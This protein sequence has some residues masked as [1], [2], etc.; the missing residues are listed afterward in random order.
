MLTLST[1]VHTHKAS[2]TCCTHSVQRK[3]IGKFSCVCGKSWCSLVLRSVWT[4][5]QGSSGGQCWAL[6][7]ASVGP[8][9]AGLLDQCEGWGAEQTDA[10]RRRRAHSAAAADPLH[11]E[12]RSRRCLFH[13]ICSHPS[14]LSSVNSV[15]SCLSSLLVL[16]SLAS[17][18]LSCLIS[19]L[20]LSPH[21]DSSHLV[22]SPHLNSCV[23]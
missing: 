3:T 15:S 1:T 21:L 8:G 18:F 9:G 10:H 11:G 22:S 12:S 2:F 4:C 17:S 7:P 16:V 5:V 23:V 6:E 14:R 19:S 13:L 20:V